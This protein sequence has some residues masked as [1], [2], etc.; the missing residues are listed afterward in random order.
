MQQLLTYMVN[1]TKTI[2]RALDMILISKNLER[3]ADL[4]TN[5]AEEVFFI[6]KARTIKHHVA[7]EI[8]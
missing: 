1:D 3:I 5:I 7:D 8:F 4:S 6:Y 2:S